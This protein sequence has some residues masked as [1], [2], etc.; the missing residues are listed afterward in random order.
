MVIKTALIIVLVL[1]AAGLVF[2]FSSLARLGKVFNRDRQT[3]AAAVFRLDYA[4]V[5]FNTLLQVR[6]FRAGKFRWLAHGLVFTGFIYLLTVHALDEWTQNFFAWYQ[7]G[8]E[9]FR[10]LRN[11]AGAMVGLGCLIFL[12]RRVS[13]SRINRE[14]LRRRLRFR[15]RGT[16]SVVVILCLIGS[17]F[18]AEGLNIASEY[19]FDEMVEEYSDLSGEP[20]LVHLQAYWARDYHVAFREAL[21]AATDGEGETQPIDLEEG[22]ELNEAYCLECHT[23]PDTAFVGA[24]LAR[25]A[26]PL[27]ARAGELRPDRVFYWLHVGLAFV[28]L[29][30]FPFSRMFHLIAI[31]LATARRR[32]PPDKIDDSMGFL[33]LAGLSAC[34]HCGFCS[35]VCSVYPD[36]QV[37]DNPQVLPHVKIE[38]L[39]RLSGKGIWDPGV[40][41]RLRSGNDDCTRCGLCADICP[42]GI[43]L[44]RLWTAADALMDRL[45]C[46][47][48]YTTAM[49][50]SFRQWTGHGHAGAVVPGNIRNLPGQI[51]IREGAGAE[52]EGLS[53]LISQAEAF[54]HCVQCTLCTNACPVAAYDLGQNDF[55]PHQVMNLLRLGEAQMASGSKMVWHCLTCYMCQEV[56]PQSIRVADILLELRCRGQARAAELTREQLKGDAG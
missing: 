40:V 44:V 14:R 17:G 55:G 1:C 50:A 10:F 41:M 22:R 46:P 21:T 36:Y 28:L 12:A 56:C 49:D 7:P 11:L 9:P 42:S 32:M 13:R 45:G 53:G 4:G 43:D 54:E 51:D 23:Q 6:L 3:L 8:I 2:R 39:K 16:V 35:Q 15:V 19:R 52:A 20:E 5:L 37:S 48:N 25:L 24:P 30:F 18:L 27:G 26:G 33:D 29:M 34:T 31:P 38:T 47:G